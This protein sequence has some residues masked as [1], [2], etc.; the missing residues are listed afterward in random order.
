MGGIY[1]NVLTIYLVS[2][3]KRSCLAILNNLVNLRNSVILENLKLKGG[4]ELSKKVKL[5]DVQEAAKKFEYN[6]DLVKKEL[7][8]IQSIKCRL[9][10]QKARK[11]Y[12]VA[13]REVLAQEQLLKEVRQLL[14]PRKKPTT[15]LTAEDIEKLTYEETIRAIKNIQSKKCLSQHL[16]DNLETNEEYQNAV[17]IEKMLLEHKNKI[18]PAPANFVAKSKIQTIIDNL[19]SLKDADKDTIVQQLKELLK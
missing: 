4:F 11:D 12:E 10:K 2:N 17:R 18:K 6:L 8:R 5:S 14:N 9:K 7:K 16:T 15:Q 3:G 19:E 1:Q 13:M